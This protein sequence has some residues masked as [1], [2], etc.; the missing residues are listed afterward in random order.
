MNNVTSGSQ[1]QQ[2][3]GPHREA[4]DYGNWWG[5]LYW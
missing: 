5:G 2:Q 4:D 1:L 3:R